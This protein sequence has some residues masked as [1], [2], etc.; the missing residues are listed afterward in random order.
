MEYTWLLFNDTLAA[1]K[2]TYSFTSTQGFA[3]E[4]TWKTVDASGAIVNAG[5]KKTRQ[6]EGQAQT[7]T[8]PS[9]PQLN[10]ILLI[11]GALVVVG[12]LIELGLKFMHRNKG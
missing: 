6:G 9:T 11:L 4:G 10:D 2:I 5:V 12:V 7:S 8:A 3:V 1:G